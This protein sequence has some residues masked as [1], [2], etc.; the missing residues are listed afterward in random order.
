LADVAAWSRVNQTLDVRDTLVWLA[1]EPSKSIPQ[2]KAAHGQGELRPIDA[3]VRGG[4][5]G[6]VAVVADAG[7]CAWTRAAVRTSR[8][9][10]RR[11]RAMR[12]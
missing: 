1:D 5:C 11:L 7:V 12:F 3:G 4:V 2:S 10:G 9:G 6:F 8:P